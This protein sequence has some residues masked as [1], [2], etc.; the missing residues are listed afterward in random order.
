MVLTIILQLNLITSKEDAS[1]FY[2][3]TNLKKNYQIKNN[4]FQK[5]YFNTSFK[6]LTI[7][8]FFLIRLKN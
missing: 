3:K 6:F 2:L 8:V 4:L 5:K 1:H 7:S